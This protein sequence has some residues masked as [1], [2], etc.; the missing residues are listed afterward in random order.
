MH[1]VIHLKGRR[2]WVLLATL[3]LV[4]TGVYIASPSQAVPITASTFDAS[5][6]NQ[7]NDGGGETDWVDLG[8][9]P[10]F[11]NAIGK[12]DNSLAGGTKDDTECPA[13]TTGSIPPNKDD[14]RHWYFDSDEITVADDTDIFFYLAYV[15]EVGSDTASAH[16]VFELNQVSDG[17]PDIPGK[18]QQP[19]T[20]SVFNDR[21][22][23]DVRLLFDY[24]GGDNPVISY[25]LWDD[26]AKVW[27]SP[28][29]LPP[30]IAQGSVN[31]GDILD[32]LN[33]DA[34]LTNREFAEV[35]INM[36]EAGLIP[37]GD[38][39]PFAEAGLFTGAS[40]NSDNEQSKDFIAPVRLDF[41]FCGDLQI[42]KYIDVDESASETAGDVVDKATDTEG[43]LDGWS[44]SVFE[45]GADPTTATA[46]CT[47]TTN[48][49]G[50]LLCEDLD[51]GDYDVYENLSSSP[52]GFINT[53]PGDPS[54]YKKDVTVEQ[55]GTTTV[56]FGNTCQITKT[57]EVTGVPDSQT[58]I[59]A[60]YT[61]TADVD[62]PI[63]LIDQTTVEVALSK[64]D[65]E[66][67]G[68][69][70]AD[71]DTYRADATEKFSVHDVITWGFGINQN[72]AAEESIEVATGEDFADEGYPTCA[73]TNSTEFDTVTIT[74][75]KFKDMDANGAKN[76][77]EGLAP[78][79]VGFVF[80]LYAGHDVDVTD[81]TPDTLVATATYDST[82][83]SDGVAPSFGDFQFLDIGP[84][85][86]TLV[87]DGVTDWVQTY[88]TSPTY[89]NVTVTLAA[90]DGGSTVITTDKDGTTL[91]FGNAP[92]VNF[93]VVVSHPT[94]T[95][96]DTHTQTD[97]ITCT[98]TAG[99]SGSTPSDQSTAADTY[100]SNDLLVGTFQC[101]IVV[102][103]P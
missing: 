84:G 22:D 30:T 82:N 23:D 18:G 89:Y 7:T 49:E 25:Q 56:R 62:G 94:N 5:D 29:P 47:G 17:C 65:N 38:C 78:N 11:D 77:S 71:D 57:F 40:G 72:T 50:V 13:T 74:G 46:V 90:A 99:P 66:G 41:N 93:D 88:P 96:N 61:K 3:A 32:K 28:V 86:Y 20:E 1:T 15:R 103:D 60:Y 35:K 80:K 59:F 31:S 34:T 95:A 10:I 33:G 36:S 92:E 2:T 26:T 79:N 76:G 43:D 55:N 58:G 91:E 64:V 21:T 4:L 6:G 83:D 42:E 51:A 75:S 102:S 98:R 16:G 73:K 14:L 52:S 67:G 85:Q 69:D 39:E 70:T 19:P 27:S 44:F 54:P 48:D 101:T 100:D 63:A 68:P 81:A 37:D 9:D 53:D 97:S 87:E 8:V 45:D 24:E 12:D